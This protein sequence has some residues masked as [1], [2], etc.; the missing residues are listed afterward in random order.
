LL[1]SEGYLVLSIDHHELVN[2]VKMCDEI[3]GESNRIGIIT[4]VHKPEGR[5][6]ER[7]F[8][9]SNEFALFYAKNRNNTDFNKVAISEDVKKTF[10]ERDEKGAYRLN[11]YRRDGGGDA[12]L[13]INKPHFWY[14][15]YVSKDLETIT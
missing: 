1:S 9:T 14:P 13:K 2:T 10:T 11:N 12:N 4:I 5:N 8:G 6:Q 15:I 3:F 7:F